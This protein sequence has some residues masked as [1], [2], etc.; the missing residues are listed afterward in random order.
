MCLEDKK[1]HQFSENK[2]QI[3]EISGFLTLLTVCRTLM[4]FSRTLSSVDLKVTTAVRGSKANSGI[5]RKI[6][7]EALRPISIFEET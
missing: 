3:L 2:F 4:N 1:S 6:M 7:S 5:F